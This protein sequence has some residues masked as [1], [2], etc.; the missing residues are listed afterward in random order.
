[1]LLCLLDARTQNEARIVIG[2]LYFRMV[3]QREPSVCN[4]IRYIFYSFIRMIYLGWESIYLQPAG[5][6]PLSVLRFQR[7]GKDRSAVDVDKSHCQFAAARIDPHLA[8]KLKT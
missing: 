2:L 6:K 3:F 4:F 8:E 5:T 7:S 1:M